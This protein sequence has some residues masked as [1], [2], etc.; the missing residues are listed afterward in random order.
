[1][2]IDKLKHDYQFDE[3]TFEIVCDDCGKSEEVEGQFQDCLDFMKENNW[4]SVYD[5]GDWYNYCPG[6]KDKPKNK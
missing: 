4:R 2:S 5:E 1:M 3:S 6:C